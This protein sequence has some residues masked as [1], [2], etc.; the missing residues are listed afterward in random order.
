MAEVDFGKLWAK[1]PREESHEESE[2]LKG[3]SS[4]EGFFYHSQLR[5]Y[6]V[7]FAAVFMG[8]KVRVGWNEDKQPRLAPVIIKNASSDRVVAA[9][10]GE[11]TQNKPIRLPMMSVQLMDLDMVPDRRHGVG[12]ERRNAFMPTGGTFPDD[13]TVVNQRM[14]VPYRGNFELTIWAS[15]Q[16]QNYQILEQ[17][18]TVF[19]PDIQIQ[20]SDETFDW[21]KLS[22]VELLDVR[23]EENVPMGSDQRLIQSTLTFGVDIYLEIPNVVHDRFIKEVYLRIGVVNNDVETNYDII[24]DLDA[25]GLEYEK[26]FDLDNIELD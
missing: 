15:N 11:N 24:A 20:R 9:I 17:I 22:Y 13:I 5:R 3:L 26:I 10:K 6:I 4:A 23:L 14:P 25:Q 21:T 12:Q 7:Q 18:L 2:Y 8:M 1:V 16:D 19:D